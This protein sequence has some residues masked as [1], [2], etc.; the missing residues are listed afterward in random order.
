MDA[1][2]EPIKQYPGKQQVERAVKV[3]VPGKH[4]T[5]LTQAEQ[6]LSYEATAVEYRERHDFERHVKAWGAAH[7]GPGI[8]FVCDSDAIDDPDHKGFWTTLG[9][10][11]RWRHDTYKENREA[12]LQ[13]L[14]KQPEAPAAPAAA[15]AAAQKAAPPEIKSYFEVVSTEKAPY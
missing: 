13:Y 1:F 4:F 8:R 10:W 7:K 14:D 9:L 11:N 15:D 5:G 3:N 6:K 12:E 2:V